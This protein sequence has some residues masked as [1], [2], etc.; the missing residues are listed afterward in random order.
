VVLSFLLC[1]AFVG[2]W[3]GVFFDFCQ[4]RVSDTSV[5]RGFLKGGTFFDV[6][7]CR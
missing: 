2:F 1:V 6:H 5:H 4:G 3:E 7:A